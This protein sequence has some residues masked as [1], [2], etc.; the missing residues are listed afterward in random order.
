[1]IKQFL[2]DNE[3]NV[4]SFVTI[5]I[6]IVGVIII[7]SMW[8]SNVFSKKEEEPRIN[9]YTNISYSEIMKEEYENVLY[10]LLKVNNYEQLYEKIDKNYLLKNN[11]DSI[12]AK[13]FLIKNNYIGNEIEII[14]CNVIKSDEIYIFRFYYKNYSA[15]KH[16]NVVEYK[17]NEYYISF[18]EEVNSLLDKKSIVKGEENGI[19]YELE[20]LDIKTDSVK[21]KINITNN[22]SLPIN[23]DFNDI[24]SF[25]ILGNEYSIPLASVVAQDKNEITQ[26]SSVNKE[27]YFLISNNDYEVCDG[28]QINNIEMNGEYFDIL[29]EL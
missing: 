25:T 28:I 26:Y 29:I 5:F 17:P 12:D 22:N 3:E 2:K 27:L 10:R 6:I 21:F 7:I 15:Y 8:I 11:L 23:I 19:S 1:M 13:N 14:S 9:S 4:I 18:E 24:N 20:L 16:V